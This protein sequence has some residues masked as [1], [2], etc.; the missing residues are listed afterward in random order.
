MVHEHERV[1]RLVSELQ[2]FLFSMGAVE[3]RTEIL[4]T[5]DRFNVFIKGNTRGNICTKL[6]KLRKLLKMPRQTSMEEELW[7]L[8][9]SVD[10]DTE[11]SLVG[12]MTDSAEVRC[13]GEAG[14]VEIELMRKK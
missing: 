14:V 13:D 5:T 2:N 12:M 11:L 1:V 10:Y 9:G 3:I 6:E 7:L 8:A 4:E